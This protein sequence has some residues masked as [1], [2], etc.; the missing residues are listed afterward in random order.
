MSNYKGYLQDKNGN[1]IYNDDYDTGWIQV[2][3]FLNEAGNYNP[4]FPVSYRKIGKVVYLNGLL[5]GGSKGIQFV[6]PEGFRPKGVYNAWICRFGTNW[7]R[8]FVNY[9]NQDGAIVC[10]GDPYSPLNMEIPLSNISFIAD[11]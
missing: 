2:T 10:E 3:E 5:K 11:Y 9:E 7:G 8:V 1:K 4:L 6:L